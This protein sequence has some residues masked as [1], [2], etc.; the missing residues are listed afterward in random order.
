LSAN[1]PVPLS[2]DDET[3][4]RFVD[5]AAVETHKASA[6]FAWLQKVEEEEGNLDG[7]IQMLPLE[8]FAGFESR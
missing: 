4:N 5:Q 7:P 3:A 2:D 6:K 1:F 8:L